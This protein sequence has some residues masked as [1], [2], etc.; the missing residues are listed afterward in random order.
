MY[1][2][3]IYLCEIINVNKYKVYWLFYMLIYTGNN[4]YF[5]YSSH[6]NN[7]SSIVIIIT[8]M[9][10]Y[11]FTFEFVGTSLEKIISFLKLSKVVLRNS[12]WSFQQLSLLNS[13]PIKSSC[14]T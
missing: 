10:H 11:N 5:L 12:I 1:N 9:R 3:K 13:Y 7:A 14:S 8:L 2:Y 4:K 6:V